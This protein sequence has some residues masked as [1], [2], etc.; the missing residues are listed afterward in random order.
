MERQHVTDLQS[1]CCQKWHQQEQ[2]GTRFSK[3]STKCMICLGSL[4][5]TYGPTVSPP[6][7]SPLTSVFLSTY[8]STPHSM[9]TLI[10]TSCV[11][12][13]Q[14]DLP[15]ATWQ[16]MNFTGPAPASC[17]PLIR[18][19]C[20]GV[21]VV[22]WLSLPYSVSNVT[23]LSSTPWSWSDRKVLESKTHEKHVRQQLVGELDAILDIFWLLVRV[24]GV[25]GVYIPR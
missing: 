22:A 17:R 4:V 21:V 6:S 2:K 15:E 24:G 1:A 7:T 20:V 3:D 12:V 10:S 25:G 11:L 5:G 8:L 16:D 18:R 23:C 14:N 19:C 9:Q 13:Q